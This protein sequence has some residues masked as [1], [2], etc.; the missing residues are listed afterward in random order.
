MQIL[1][2]HVGDPCIFCGE[3]YDTIVVGPCPMRQSAPMY[4]Q[5]KQ[6]LRRCAFGGSFDLLPG[7]ALAILDELAACHHTQAG[8]TQP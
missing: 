7:E 6:E 1:T 2:A 8:G 4:A 5:A 3:T